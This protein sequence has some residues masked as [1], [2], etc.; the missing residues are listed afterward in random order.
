MAATTGEA[1]AGSTTFPRMPS[2]LVPSPAQL[3]P[4]KPSAAIVEPTSPPNSACDELDGSPSSQVSRFQ[5][6]PPISPQNTISSSRCPLSAR[7][8]AFGMPLLSWIFTTAFVTVR[9]TW[10]ERKAPT[11]LSTADSSTAVLGWRAPVAIEVAIALPVSW[12]PF[13]KSK[14]MAVTTTST[15]IANSRFTPLIVHD[16]ATP[17]SPTP[18]V[19]QVTLC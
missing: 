18:A 2:S 19:G 5:K 17:M 11:R 16:G 14:P 4:P 10:T 9:A 3:T 13:V 8:C 12:K 7:N 15:R 1:S 6:M